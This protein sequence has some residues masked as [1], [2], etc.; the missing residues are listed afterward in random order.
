M[1]FSSSHHERKH[2]CP[3]T[4][5]PQKQPQPLHVLLAPLRVLTLNA[6]KLALSPVM[7]GSH[8]RYP[9]REI[10]KF[11]NGLV[12]LIQDNSSGICAL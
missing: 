11:L 7:G 12:L 4:P 5:F 2:R 1:A 8:G 9:D 10:F 6:L 3:D